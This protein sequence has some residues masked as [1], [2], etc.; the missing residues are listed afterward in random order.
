MLLQAGGKQSEPFY[1]LYIPILTTVLDHSQVITIH[2]NGDSQINVSQLGTL[3]HTPRLYPRQKQDQLIP[4]LSW[5][6]GPRLFTP[7]FR[8]ERGNSKASKIV[9]IK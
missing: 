7:K 5:D 2:R 4:L 6:L 1:H 9:P 3:K 8:E